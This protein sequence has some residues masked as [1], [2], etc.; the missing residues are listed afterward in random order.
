VV[1]EASSP[2]GIGSNSNGTSLTSPSDA[3]GISGD[4]LTVKVVYFGMPQTVTSSKEEYF[5]LQS[6]AYFRDI[7]S[8][9]AEKHPLI[10]TMIPTMI[11][12][13]DGVPRQPSRALKDGGEI[14]VVPAIAGG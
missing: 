2:S 10:S 13:V 11:I 1:R 3:S 8:E 14:E 5:T 12:S 6:P 9:V 4:S 7:L